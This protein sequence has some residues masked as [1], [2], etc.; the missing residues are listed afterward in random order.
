MIERDLSKGQ[1]AKDDPFLQ[2]N[3]RE[4]DT[5]LPQHW[6]DYMVARISNLFVLD[7]IDKIIYRGIA[8]GTVWVY[9]SKS[10]RGNYPYPVS[11]NVFA[12]MACNMAY[13][14]MGLIPAD[15]VIH[16]FGTEGVLEHE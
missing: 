4:Y 11:K 16:Q 14:D 3:D 10:G 12:H 15:I 9:E 7:N 8:F 1:M 13:Q 2:S 6:L 5:A